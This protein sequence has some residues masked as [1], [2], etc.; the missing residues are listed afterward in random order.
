MSEDDITEYFDSE[1]ELQQ[2]AKKFASLVK[3]SKHFVVYTG[4]GVS[5]AAKI[6]DYRG[7]NGVWTLKAQG[8]MPKM[9]ISLE[10]A[11]PTYTHMAL[12]KLFQEGLLHYVVS[13]NCDGL[14]RRSGIPGNGISEVHGN[15]YREYCMDC[16]AEYLRPFDVRFKGQQF[17]QSRRTT[18]R[19]CEKE[20]CTGK[21][22]DSIVNFGEYLPEE[23]FSRAK[24]H[25]KQAD[26]TLVLGSSMLVEPACSL[27]ASSYNRGG[28]FNICNLQKTQFDPVVGRSGGVRVFGKC[29]EFMTL[30]M[31]ELDLEVPEFEL[32]V[33]ELERELSSIVMDTDSAKK[34]NCHSMADDGP[35]PPGV[36][37]A[38]ESGFRFSRH[39]T[40]NEKTGAPVG[41][42]V[43]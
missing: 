30:V 8:K 35:P 9:K 34:Y 27:P 17:V 13:T 29:D 19:L 7:P 21:L 32:D 42:V 28:V 4:A 25:S 39:I 12:V 31:R 11:V 24:E 38:I 14:H 5:T 33:E 16:G 23:E 20:N 37:S 6:P 40:P 2:S 18:G 3:S 15:I 43:E 41:R 26:L 1:E 36:L 22:R 10:A